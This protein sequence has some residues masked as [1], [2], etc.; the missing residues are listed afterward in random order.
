M[1][2]LSS[3]W[4]NLLYKTLCF[5]CVIHENGSW[6]NVK[7]RSLFGNWASRIS[8][9]FRITRKT[10]PFFC[11]NSLEYIRWANISCI[12][13]GRLTLICINVAFVC[14]YEGRPKKTLRR[15][16]EYIYSMAQKYTG[17]CRA[18]EFKK[19]GVCICRMMKRALSVAWCAHSP[20][21]HLS[22]AQLTHHTLYTRAL[23][24][25]I[26]WDAVRFY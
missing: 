19:L 7:T 5:D 16:W 9:E 8:T 4:Y 14:V 10:R 22:P 13:A 23:Y 21:L 15:T 3:L 20:S 26:N 17:G 24:L 1:L 12:C 18:D 6:K 2:Y 11:A 25:W